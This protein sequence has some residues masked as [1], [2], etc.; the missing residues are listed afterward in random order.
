MP[1]NASFAWKG[2][3]YELAQVA[4]QLGARCVLE[5]SIRK[6]GGSLRIAGR[7]IDGATGAHLW[8]DRYDGALEEVFDVQD[9]VTAAVVGANVPALTRAET[10]RAKRKP[11]ASLDAYDNFLRGAALSRQFHPETHRQACDHFYRAME[12]A[13]DFSTPFGFATHCYSTSKLQGWDFD[14][15]AAEAEVRRLAEQVAI[16]GPDDAWAQGTAGFSL[17]WVCRD[18]AAAAAFGDTALSLN[19]NLLSAWMMRDKH[20]LWVACAGDRAVVPRPHNQPDRRPIFPCPK[21]ISPSPGCSP[22]AS[23]RRPTPSAMPP[24]TCPTG[25]PGTLPT[26]QPMPSSATSTRPAR[27]LPWSG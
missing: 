16:I 23:R 26:L 27:A 5:G 22:G 17:A 25:W 7:L 24:R 1:R 18:Y 15:P 14:P 12:L 9:R 13:P 19:P 20:I 2:K 11:V 6:A 21:A 8:S 3:R 10:E 4:S